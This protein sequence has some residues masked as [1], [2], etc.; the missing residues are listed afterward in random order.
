MSTANAM[1]DVQTG[2]EIVL[3]ERMQSELAEPKYTSAQIEM[4][5]PARLHD[6]AKE[7]MEGLEKVDNQVIAVKNL[8]A[9]VKA[10]CDVGGFAAF[11]EKFF[12]MAAF[13]AVS[14]A[15]RYS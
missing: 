6:L 1:A 14:S 9:E 12:P 3:S 7:I 2:Q 8:I 11:R 15:P 5:C 13:R 4:D 10:L